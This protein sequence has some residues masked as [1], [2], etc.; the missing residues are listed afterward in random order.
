MEQT[1]YVLAIIETLYL[2]GIKRGAGAHNEF[3]IYMRT[4]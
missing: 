4:V 1:I 2:V 3:N